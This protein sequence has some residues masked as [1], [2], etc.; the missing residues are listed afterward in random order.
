MAYR[1]ELIDNSQTAVPFLS[2]SHTHTPT[3]IWHV[4]TGVLFPRRSLYGMRR[5]D[6]LCCVYTYVDDRPTRQSSNNRWTGRDRTDGNE[7]KKQ[8]KTIIYVFLEDLSFS[9]GRNIPLTKCRVRRSGSTGIVFRLKIF[10]RVPP[11]H[12]YVS[13][14]LANHNYNSR[15]LC[16]NKRCLKKINVLHI[17]RM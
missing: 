1:G 8:K 2:L 7:T 15:V 9:C 12:V 3:Q 16:D 17:N 11:L 5:D 14:L 10:L 13:D 4:K 6:S